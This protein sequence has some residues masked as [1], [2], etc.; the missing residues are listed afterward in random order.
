MGKNNLLIIYQDSPKDLNTGKL[1]SSFNVIIVPRVAELNLQNFKFKGHPLVTSYND[2]LYANDPDLVFFIGSSDFNNRLVKKLLKFNGLEKNF[3][4]FTRTKKYSLIVSLSGLVIKKEVLLRM[5]F[6]S[7]H[8][9]NNLYL[10][11]LINYSLFYGIIPGYSFPKIKMPSRDFKK[12]SYWKY[13]EEKFY[14]RNPLY[15]SEYLNI[16]P[17]M[18]A[19][20]TNNFIKKRI[21]SSMKAKMSAS[22][23]EI[24]DFIFSN[25][26]LNYW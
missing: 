2:I 3:D 26:Y 16:S 25:T 12:Y 23:P 22:L 11:F 24:E 8:T 18:D 10:N 20:L 1:N 6:L 14:Y 17:G 7:K 4:F 9:F 13:Y 21:A 15:K 5:G 19:I